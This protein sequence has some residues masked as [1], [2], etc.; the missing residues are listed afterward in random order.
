MKYKDRQ[1]DQRRIVYWLRHNL[2]KLGKV[3]KL[4]EKKK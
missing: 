4:V 1:N 2:T 3:L